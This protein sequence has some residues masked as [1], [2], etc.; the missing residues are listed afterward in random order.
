MLWVTGTGGIMARHVMFDQTDLLLSKGQRALRARDFD[1]AINHLTRAIETDPEYPHL[2]MYLGIA[3]AEAGKAREAEAA[4]EKAATLG[5]GNF[6][7]PMEL[8]ILRLDEEDPQGAEAYFR[9]AQI[10]APDNQLVVGYL[11]LCRLDR[12]EGVALR[13]VK[14]ALQ[15]LPH[16]FRAR[17]VARV[18]HRRL[19]QH[20]AGACLDAIHPS[21]SNMGPRLW[22]AWLIQRRQTR[23][24]RSAEALLL[25]GAFEDA[26][27]YIADRPWLSTCERGARFTAHARRGAA[28]VLKCALDWLGS[29]QADGDRNDQR[30]G[31]LF[32]L[33]SHQYDLEDYDIAYETLSKC[34]STSF[35]EPKAERD[36]ISLATVLIRMADLSIR[37]AAYADAQRLCAEARRLRP[38]PELHWVEAIA[39][40]GMNDLRACRQKIEAFFQAQ[41]FRADAH[42]AA[43]METGK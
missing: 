22:P 7:F 40:L 11:V 2:Y 14:P 33:A 27:S 31:L 28:M 6:V 38:S 41:P 8:G 17:V 35:S 15:D 18:E 25:R 21:P 1:A 20:G 39:H 37:R 10:L 30:R 24:L 26:L 12:G 5:P 9:R 3:Q 23:Q 13:E 42:V 29:N 16:A 4:L 34:R 19:A 32:R 43:F 36:R